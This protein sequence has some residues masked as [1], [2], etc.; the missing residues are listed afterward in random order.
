MDERSAETDEVVRRDR[1]A[2]TAVV[3]AYNEEEYIGSCIAGLLAQEAVD[4]DFEILVVDG[5]STDR[6]VDVVRSFP[7]YGTR[8]RL[9]YNRLKLQVHAWNIGLREMR[10][11]YFAMITAHAQYA[12]D[13][14]SRCIETLERTGAAAVG[15]V[16][17]ASGEG[18]I[19]R[20]V[21]WCMSTPFGVGGARFRY[22]QRE[23]ECDTV[24]LI[25]SRRDAIE[26]LG[27]WDETIAF[28]EDSDL[29]YRI[30]AHGGKLVVSPSI[31]LRYFVRRSLR[32][33]CK[34]M[35][36]YGYW[37]RFTQLKHPGVV[38][39]RV[40]APAALVAGFAASAL[41]LF[42]PL[43]ILAGV[44]PAS[45]AAFLLVAM[46]ASAPELGPG[47]ICVPVTL[48][49]MHVSYGV[50]WWK[51]FALLHPLLSGKRRRSLAR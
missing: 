47:A 5:M 14:L 10:G 43:R 51:A 25:F 8:V 33:L 45:Y 19:G 15:G 2:V 13:Y 49:V 35:Y 38:P 34:Q 22:L 29:A 21:A 23:E 39:V 7:E 42:T 46:V 18:W 16:P 27:G 31:R 17:R 20:A 12:P 40:L 41:L 6:T 48:G 32:S 44:I 28:D 4:G 11:E 24:P 36:R 30:R 9:V 37:R 3:A 26:R 50:G 1:L